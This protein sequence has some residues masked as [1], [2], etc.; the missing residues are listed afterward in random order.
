MI[1]T[2][3]VVSWKHKDLQ[4]WVLFL[5]LLIFGTS[6]VK[7]LCVTKTHWARFGCSSVLLSLTNESGKVWTLWAFSFIHVLLHL[8][9]PVLKCCQQLSVKYHGF[10]FCLIRSI[11]WIPLAAAKED[12]FSQGISRLW[13]EAF[14]CLFLWLELF[15]TVQRMGKCC[16]IKW[17]LLFNGTW[18]PRVYV[19]Q[20]WIELA[21]GCIWPGTRCYK[22]L[23]GFQ[24]STSL[25]C[26]IVL[27]Q[28]TDQSKAWTISQPWPAWM[29]GWGVQLE[30]RLAISTR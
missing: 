30:L 2:W 11:F 29:R 12:L 22:I 27:K 7:G 23:A 4:T 13:P 19:Q 15:T 18:I 6:G 5:H 3:A 9:K 26:Q 14:L 8:I 1:R 10:F 16:S 21:M 25:V 28:V 17:V 20:W 24:P